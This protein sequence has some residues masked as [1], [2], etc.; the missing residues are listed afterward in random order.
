[1]ISLLTCTP[2]TSQGVCLINTVRNWSAKIVVLFSWFF[3][4]HFSGNTQREQYFP[5]FQNTRFWV[6]RA[7]SKIANKFV[8]SSRGVYSTLGPLGY[9]RVCWEKWTLCRVT[10]ENLNAHVGRSTYRRARSLLTKWLYYI[11]VEVRRIPSCGKE[12]W[13]M[14][15]IYSCM[16]ILYV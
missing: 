2:R 4:F 11:G 7:A 12:I 5:K 1:M 9:D 3:V 15:D 16:F 14:N 8:F 13:M 6:W 10:S